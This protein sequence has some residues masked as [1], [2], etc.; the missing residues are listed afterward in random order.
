MT[1]TDGLE[2]ARAQDISD[3]L[4]RIETKLDIMLGIPAPAPKPSP[5]EIRGLLASLDSFRSRVMRSFDEIE[6][7]IA[8]LVARDAA[9]AARIRDTTK[10]TR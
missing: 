10:E 7:T 4:T 1:T 8:D 2:A 5:I 9:E 6:N 3:V